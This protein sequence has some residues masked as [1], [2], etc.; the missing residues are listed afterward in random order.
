[1]AI[2]HR[3][4]ALHRSS[5]SRSEPRHPQTA[6]RCDTLQDQ[7]G[8][9]LRLWHSPPIAAARSVNRQATATA[10]AAGQGRGLCPS[11]AGADVTN[12]RPTEFPQA[13]GK[14]AKLTSDDEGAA[15][16]SSELG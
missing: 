5:L 11:P 1:M 6:R 10:C 4:P 9:R 3:D 15:K 13:S 7:L 8:H 2:P 14:M 16:V 12:N